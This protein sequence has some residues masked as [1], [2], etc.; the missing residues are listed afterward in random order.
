[1]SPTLGGILISTRG[2]G[3]YRRAAKSIM[4]ATRKIVEASVS[5][6]LGNVTGL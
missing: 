6:E 4:T 3:T 5:R 1:M 2:A